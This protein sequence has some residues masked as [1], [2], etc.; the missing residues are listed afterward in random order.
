MFSSLHDDSCA[1]PQFR[2]PQQSGFHY[3]DLHLPS[4][5]LN[6][7]N[8]M[9]NCFGFFLD[10]QHR[11]EIFTTAENFSKTCKSRQKSCAGADS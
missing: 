10:H 9:L 3:H 11:A 7:Q 6:G 8:F 2:V 4:F 1:L 5:S